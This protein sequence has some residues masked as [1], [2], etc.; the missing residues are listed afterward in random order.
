MP[1]Q[2]LAEVEHFI[3]GVFT[4]AFA[5]PELAPRLQA[6]GLVLR[7][8]LSEP[9]TVLVAD[10]G[11]LTVGRP[12]EDGP[13]SAGAT[14]DVTL[15]MSADTANAYW[16]GKVGLPLAM[17][18]GRIAVDGNVAA[19]LRLAPLGKKM[20]PVYTATLTAAGRTDLL[21]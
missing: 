21:H 10:L 4:G 1:F 17:A 15:R 12:D 6:T 14:A 19:L 5:D 11:A 3:G 18:R 13:G 9:A 20:Y 7:L 8:E 2:D 16:Q